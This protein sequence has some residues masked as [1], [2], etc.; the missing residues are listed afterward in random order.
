MRTYV[1]TKCTL[2]KVLVYHFRLQTG[3]KVNV[4]GKCKQAHVPAAGL[5]SIRHD[6]WITNYI[7]S[8]KRMTAF[9]QEYLSL[10]SDYLRVLSTRKDLL[11]SIY[12]S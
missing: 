8:T 3:V 2:I 1:T 4:V 11:M 5:V 9:T 10:I 7:M 6:T 12:H